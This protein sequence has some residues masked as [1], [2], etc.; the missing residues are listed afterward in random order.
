MPTP[1]P[2]HY[3]VSLEAGYGE[4]VLS[5]ESRPP[6][7]AGA[8]PEF[9]GRSDVW[10]P[11]HLLLSA[12]VVCHYTTFQALA[13][14]AKLEIQGYHAS[15]RGELAKTKE[16]L[17]FTSFEIE[18]TVEVPPDAAAHA[19]GLLQAAK[20]HCLVANALKTPVTLRS[21]VRRAA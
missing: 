6:L 18:V 8:P 9:D 11:E 15:A 17:A 1:F 4:G 20:D 16:G 14:R 12:L 3:Q 19:Q 10:S 2:H 21:S 13:G 5:S 7:L